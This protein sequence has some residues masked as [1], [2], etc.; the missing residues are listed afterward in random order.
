MNNNIR[1]NL[2]AAKKAYA[3]SI[4]VRR[5]MPNGHPRKAELN[6]E[7]SLTLAHIKMLKTN[8]A[9]MQAAS[10]L[11]NIQ[12]RVNK[13]RRAATKIQSAWRAYNAEKRTRTPQ[14]LTRALR[15]ESRRL[16]GNNK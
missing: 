3:N 15:A 4:A 9:M 12:G 11:L 16:K 6:R 14:T 5:L 8:L 13:R 1:R 7:L 2:N 10:V